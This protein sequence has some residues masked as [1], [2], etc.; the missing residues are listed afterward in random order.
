MAARRGVAREKLELGTGPAR[1]A[2]VADTHSRPHPAAAGHLAALQPAA[3]LHAGDIGELAVLDGLRAIAP[4]FA[5]RGNIDTRARGVP[6]VL[7]LDLVRPAGALRLLLVHIA[8]HG[9]KLRADVARLA[10]AEGASLVVCGH[11]HVPF[12]GGDREL[13]VFNPG[14]IGP[15]RFSLPIVFGTIDMTGE[16]VRLSHIDC[17]TGRPWSP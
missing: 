14:S 2:V 3:I 13:A 1:I 7:T 4:V 10:R 8:V 9:P 16:R 12:I 11:S 5:V 6:D 17:E 15:R